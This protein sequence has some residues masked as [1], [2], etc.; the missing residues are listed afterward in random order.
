MLELGLPAAAKNILCL[1]AHA[2]DIEIGCGATLLKWLSQ[3]P[4][5]RV[6]W[7]VFTAEG[8]RASEARASAKAWLPKGDHKVVVKQFP[9]SY[10]PYHG[11]KVKEFF[12]ALKS[13]F[14][15]DVIFTHYLDDRHQDHRLLSEL[16]WNTYR[17]HLILEYEIPKYDGDLGAPNF[18]VPLDEKLARQKAA[19]LCRHFQTQSN[20]HWF[21]EETFLALMRL[22]GVECAST[23]AEAFYCRKLRIT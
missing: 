6:R 2:D 4:D 23:Y 19:H 14:I 10:L 7:I 11:A 9:G 12:E 18:F 17:D 8:K 22:R 15:P 21:A 13:T 1:G 20:K 3:R 16:A 5:L